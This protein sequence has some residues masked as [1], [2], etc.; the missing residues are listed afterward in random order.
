MAEIVGLDALHNAM[1]DMKKRV[2]EA[3]PSV[4]A[5]AAAPI[6]EEIDQRMPRLT[7]QTERALETVIVAD[8]Q[9]AKAVVQVRN[10]AVGEENEAAIYLEFGTSKMPAEPFFRP[11]FVAGHDK[12]V[13]AAEDVLKEAI[14]K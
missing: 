4:V 8:Q 7:G 14:A 13:Q 2:Q 12:A 6:H 10:S 5:A 3:L 1:A 11:G 9:S